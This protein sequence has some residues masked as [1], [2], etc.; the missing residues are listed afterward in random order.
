MSFIFVSFIYFAFCLMLG[1]AKR[2]YNKYLYDGFSVLSSK[3]TLYKVKYYDESPSAP[4]SSSHDI[5]LDG[6]SAVYNLASSSVKTTGVPSR[7][8][9]LKGEVAVQLDKNLVD[10]IMNNPIFFT[11]YTQIGGVFPSQSALD[12]YLSNLKKIP[13][14]KDR[15]FY[16]K[17]K[18]AVRDGAQSAYVLHFGPFPSKSD[19][20]NFCSELLQYSVECVTV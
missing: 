12:K 13:F 10:D 8:E 6:R 1:D 16:Y 14:L 17:V 18:Q 2:R 15:M 4:E 5:V 19:A 9:I 3:Y 11:F 20:K 7:E